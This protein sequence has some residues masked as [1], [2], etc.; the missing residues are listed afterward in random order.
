VADS[1]D[2]MTNPRPFA[3]RVHVD[4]GIEFIRNNAGR[5][6]DPAV[7]AAFLE[8]QERAESDKGMLADDL[9]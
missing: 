4:N 3:P 1:F 8:V 9:V 6:F 7:V 5:Y 2:A